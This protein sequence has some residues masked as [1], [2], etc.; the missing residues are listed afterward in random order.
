MPLCLPAGR[1]YLRLW[2]AAPA[3]FRAAEP[4]RALC[5]VPAGNERGS[6]GVARP[7]SSRRGQVCA[8]AVGEKA[9]D[10]W[11]RGLA[12]CPISASLRDTSLPNGEVV[13]SGVI[14]RGHVSTGQWQGWFKQKPSFSGWEDY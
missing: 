6:P 13:E 9:D 1:T 7:A 8:G 11:R 14:P 4:G 5:A 3:P 2:G 10:T 12:T